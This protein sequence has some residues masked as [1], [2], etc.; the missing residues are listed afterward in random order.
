[1]QE[2]NKLTKKMKGEV[3]K[4]MKNWTVEKEDTKWNLSDK[5]EGR[6]YGVCNYEDVFLFKD[7]KEA[8]KILKDKFKHETYWQRVCFEIDKVFGDKLI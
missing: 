1:M 6:E 7:V 8:V 4:I 3:R 2:G 5:M